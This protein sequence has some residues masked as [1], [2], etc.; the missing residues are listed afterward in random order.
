M[1]RKNL[2]WSAPLLAVGFFA[3]SARADAPT[4]DEGFSFQS[5]EWSGVSET[6]GTPDPKSDWTIKASY[7]IWGTFPARSVLRY[8]VKQKGKALGEVRCETRSL[9]NATMKNGRPHLFSVDCTNRNLK[10]REPGQYELEW[11]LIDGDTDAD[12][13]LGTDTMTVRA[14]PRYDLG[15]TTRPW[16]PVIYPDRNAELLSTVLFQRSEGSSGYL[17]PLESP[18]LKRRDGIDLVVQAAPA[19]SGNDATRS[20]YLRCKVN[21]ASVNLKTPWADGPSGGTTTDGVWVSSGRGVLAEAETPNPSGNPRVNKDPILFRTYYLQLPLVAAGG[22]ATTEYT[23]V[24][25]HPGKWECEWRN[26]ESRTLRT[27]RFSVGEN[28][29]VAPHQEQSEHRLSLAPD[30]VLVET[31]IPSDDPLDERT[32]PG[33]VASGAF[34]GRGFKSASMLALAKAIPA[35]GNPLPPKVQVIAEPKPAGAAKAAGKKKR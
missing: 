13:T 11:H 17:A 5:I 24:G 29:R 33:V 23:R 34:Q 16:Y 20:S 2:L 18:T 6:G 7:R 28:G 25:N 14:A 31:V 10:F 35:K 21:G 27:F 22:A 32:N 9:Y 30:A 4:V 3:S 26:G 8:V 15:S 19:Y 1:K 12:T